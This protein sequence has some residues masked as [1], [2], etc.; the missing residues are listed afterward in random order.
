MYGGSSLSPSIVP[1]VVVRGHRGSRV[2][3]ARWS[4]VLDDTPLAVLALDTRP[5]HGKP[6]EFGKA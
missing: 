5:H 2:L 1:T 4:G 6:F 3:A